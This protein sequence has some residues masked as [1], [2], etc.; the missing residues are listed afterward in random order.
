M[1]TQGFANIVERKQIFVGRIAYPFGG[2]I[3]RFALSDA[4]LT[5]YTDS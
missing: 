4:W 2:F 3:G 5:G 1:D